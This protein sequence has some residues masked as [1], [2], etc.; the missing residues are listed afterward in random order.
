MFGG[1]GAPS[2]GGI[3]SGDGMD[4]LTSPE[5]FARDVLVELMRAAVEEMRVRAAGSGTGMNQED[6]Q[7]QIKVSIG[8]IV[9]L[10]YSN[11]VLR[12]SQKYTE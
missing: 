6:V 7:A 9:T 4:D 10:P 12:C 11:K 8:C 3:N 1:S 2:T 5:E